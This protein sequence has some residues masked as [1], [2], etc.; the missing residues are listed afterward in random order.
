MTKLDPERHSIYPCKGK[1]IQRFSGNFGKAE[2]VK[3]NKRKNGKFEIPVQNYPN[4]KGDERE[5][6]QIRQGIW[7][8]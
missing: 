4:G 5:K 1:F 6:G 2:G 8:R 7:H 3:K